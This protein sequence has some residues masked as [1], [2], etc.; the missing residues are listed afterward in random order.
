MK[1]RAIK[2]DIY[3]VGAVDWDRRL[4]DSL[5]ALPDGTSYNSYFIKGS[6]KTALID[7][8][9]P[10]M[11]QE[12]L[13]NLEE[14][15]VTKLDYLIHNHAEPDHSGSI[16]E[17]LEKYPEATVLC[18]P[19]C[20]PLLMDR[21]G[22]PESRFKTVED[23]ETVDL[24][25]KTLEF[26]HTPWVHWPETMVTYLREAKML[27]SGDFFGSH[28]ATSSMY[29]EDERLQQEGA[30]R[31]FAEIMLPFRAI[32]Q[33]NLKKLEDYDIDIIAPS[34][35]PLYNHAQADAIVADYG[36]WT[37]DTPKN[38][39]MIPYVTMHGITRAMVERLVD[40]LMK[41][42]VSVQQFELSGADLGK[43][44]MALVDA[45]TIVIGTPTVLAGPHPLAANAAVL[46]NA[47]RPNTKFV[48]IIGSYGWGGK[49]VE[50]LTSLIPNIKAEVLPPILCKG[51]PKE[52][53]WQAI[54]N[55]AETIAK[56]HQEYEYPA[57]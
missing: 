15:G 4:F 23:K 10:P 54:D 31:Y 8:V 14:L 53:D 11:K 40:G 25:G 2:E 44:A 35:G 29:V 3:Y 39:V 17:V 12:L 28:L 47:L 55:L 45:A 34:H 13:D 42:G 19:K 56:K 21:F 46:A 16:R 9:N 7:T 38:L 49:A 32:I 22:V 41:R 36:N 57:C 43:I 52:T 37:S 26:I 48:S 5:I 50:T 33:N 6:E 51:Y 27:F 20:V 1:P 24:G 18:T 30:K